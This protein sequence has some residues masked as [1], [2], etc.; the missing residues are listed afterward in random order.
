[1]WR[2]PRCGLRGGLNRACRLR[3]CRATGERADGR[4]G[5]PG[6][7]GREGH[8]AARRLGP[9]EEGSGEASAVPPEQMLALD[10]VRQANDELTRSGWKP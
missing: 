9:K 10:F 6:G 7:P 5:R 1:V 3:A 2:P 8:A 4:G